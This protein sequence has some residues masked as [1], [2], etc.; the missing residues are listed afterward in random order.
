[1]PGQVLDQGVLRI[2]G[3]GP[4]DR[5]EQFTIW[6]TPAGHRI[7]SL[8][9]AVTAGYR[10]ECRFDYDRDWLPIGASAQAE[11]A[12]GRFTVEIA[13]QGAVARI[14]V[15]GQQGEVIRQVSFPSGCL[16]DL[17][18][19]ALPMWAMT[20]RYD[21]ARSGTQQFTWIGRSL[22]RDL[23]LE[24]GSTALAL[25][26]A[27]DGESFEFVEEL[28][29]PGGGTYRI[30]F[31]LDNNAEGWLQTFVVRASGATVRGERI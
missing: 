5:D 20:R 12:D 31:A 13:P 8:I 1:M 7:E 6:R 23:V 9:T 10:F 24:G 3:G 15:E 4:F 27:D 30:E 16:I 22:M 17:E 11:N 19:S 18:P 14:R 29:V 26:H 21:R 25:M 28:P 2:R